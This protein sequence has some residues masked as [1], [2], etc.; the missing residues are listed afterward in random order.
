M[1]R[2]LGIGKLD[3]ERLTLLLRGTTYTI[4][5]KEASN[6]LDI[7]Q[8]R[9]STL[10]ARYATKGWLSRIKAGIYIPVPL[11]AIDSDITLEDPF[12]VATKLYAP[13]YIA[14]WSA[15]EYWGLT[16]QLFS[17][18]VVFTKQKQRNKNITIK[19][20]RF[21][22]HKIPEN[23]FFGLKS[24]WR[25]QIKIKISDPSK[26][27]IDLINTPNIG[28][29]IEHVADVLSNYLKSE[30]TELDTLFHYARKLNNGTVFKRLGFLMERDSA[31][32]KKYIHYCK[33]HLTNSKA[34]L[35]PEL[36][37]N[38]LVTRWKLWVPERWKY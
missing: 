1:G 17:T 31:I 37:N 2:P 15:A 28:G 23:T 36:N 25:G 5:A 35:D 10:L 4:T 9:A 14:G 6:I 33:E 3:R 34:K 16:E 27:I 30:H 7:S 32:E 38:K 26:T 19:N 21:L 18:V 24:L 22:L 29:G 8:H 13:C 11:E 20:T 12:I